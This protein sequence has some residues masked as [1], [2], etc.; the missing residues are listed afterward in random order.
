MR[1]IRQFYKKTET[2]AHNDTFKIAGEAE[3]N[4]PL[5]FAACLSKN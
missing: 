4:S 1:I 5:G 2:I 3:N